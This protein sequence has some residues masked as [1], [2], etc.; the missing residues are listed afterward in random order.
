MKL[1]I[2]VIVVVLSVANSNAAGNEL[3]YNMTAMDYSDYIPD[4]SIA[5]SKCE[6]IIALIEFPIHLTLT[7]ISI[8]TCVATFYVYFSIRKKIFTRQAVVERHDTK[9]WIHFNFIISFIFRDIAILIAMVYQKSGKSI[10]QT[11]NPLAAY[12]FYIYINIANFYWMFDEGL[13]LYLGVFF[14]T[15]FKH[16]SHMKVKLCLIGWLL[17][18]FLMS[19]WAATEAIM[20]RVDNR[21]MWTP[22]EKGFW[23][24]ASVVCILVPVYLILVVNLMMM[25]RI[26]H[27][28]RN[29]IRCELKIKRRLARATFILSFL[30]GINFG[31]PIIVFSLHL[32]EIET[33][34]CAENSIKFLNYIISSLQ[35][36]FVAI[37]YVLSNKDVLQFFRTQIQEDLTNISPSPR[38]SRSSRTSR[39]SQPGCP[40]E[41]G[42]G[43]HIR[44]GLERSPRASRTSQSSSTLHVP[45]S[46]DARSTKKTSRSSGLSTT[47]Y[48][49]SPHTISMKKTSNTSESSLTLYVPSPDAKSKNRG[50]NFL[51][52]TDEPAYV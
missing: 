47:L 35:G 22:L 26:L 39:I 8:A 9:H 38:L 17:P 30:L 36:F 32:S 31:I 48:V 6:E 21:T 49:P 4:S 10:L 1:F 43:F 45:S 33:N 12:T 40:T 42:N 28:F 16:F 29:K 14:D 13:W 41:N 20:Y 2:A 52:K 37:F 34:P 25:I 46:P 23:E 24:P 7:C 5:Y 19:V 44:N 51:T 50:Y 3:K 27:R 15:S 11:E 18:G